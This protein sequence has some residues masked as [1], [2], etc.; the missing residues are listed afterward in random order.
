MGAL[1]FLGIG[2]YRAWRQ[3]QQPNPKRVAQAL[4]RASDMPWRDFSAALQQAFTRQGYTVAV[5]TGTAADL[6][7]TKSGRV[8]LVSCKRWKAANHGVETLRE[9]VSTKQAQAADNCIYISLG[10]VSGNAQKYAQEQAIALISGQELA[11][12]ILDAV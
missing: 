5:L 6:K 8:T 12:L 10:S 4:Q 7:L 9:L 1:P 3:W 2:L 11:H